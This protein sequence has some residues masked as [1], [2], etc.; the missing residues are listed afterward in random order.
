MSNDLTIKD[1]LKLK[2]CPF[3]GGPAIIEKN[4]WYDSG[5]PCILHTTFNV[6]CEKKATK[7]GCCPGRLCFN[8]G[9]KTKET[10]IKAWNR[11][12]K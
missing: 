3:C 4:Q 8:R 10:A 5:F 1:I 12:A 11:R 2:P 9:Y 6:G 7:R